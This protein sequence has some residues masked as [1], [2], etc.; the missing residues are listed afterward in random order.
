MFGE[1]IRL[2]KIGR[3]LGLTEKEMNKFLLFD[4]TKRPNFYRFLLLLLLMLFAF[5]TIIALFILKNYT[6]GS[7]YATGTKYSS[8]GVKDFR[9]ETKNRRIIKL[10]LK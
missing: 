7:T 9:K 5:S 2:Y 3:D 6:G 8:I 1:M 4:E 10:F